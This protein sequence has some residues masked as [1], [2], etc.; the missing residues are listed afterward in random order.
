MPVEPDLKNY[1]FCQGIEPLGTKDPNA[2]FSNLLLLAV[3]TL[4]Q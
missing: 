3:E 1:K 2:L 4:S